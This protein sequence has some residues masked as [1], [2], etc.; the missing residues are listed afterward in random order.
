[1]RVLLTF[2][3]VCERSWLFVRTAILLQEIYYIYFPDLL[4]GGRLSCVFNH[5]MVDCELNISF[6]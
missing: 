1:M 3:L 6:T 5:E 4:R 2:L